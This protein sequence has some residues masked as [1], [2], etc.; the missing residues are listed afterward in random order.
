[1]LVKFAA[2]W[3]THDLNKRVYVV[4]QQ[5]SDEL[6]IEADSFHHDDWGSPACR[7][8]AFGGQRPQK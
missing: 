1:L 5:L 6:V 8:H 7:V 4:R 2:C 3:R